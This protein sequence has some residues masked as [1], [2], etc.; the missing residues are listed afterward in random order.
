MEKTIQYLKWAKESITDRI[1]RLEQ[2]TVFDKE[3]R[4]EVQPE[5]KELKKHA[6][7]IQNTIDYFINLK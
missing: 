1:E 7:K 4:K 3:E 2:A 5:I 6:N